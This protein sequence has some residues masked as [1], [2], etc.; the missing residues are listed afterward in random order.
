MGS[1]QLHSEL[2]AGQCMKIEG[3]SVYA[4]GSGVAPPM[5][6]GSKCE[7]EV[8]SKGEQVSAEGM[9]L[10][11]GDMCAN[12]EMPTS[13]CLVEVSSYNFTVKR[14]TITATRVVFPAV[15]PPF[16]A[17]ENQ[18]GA[19]DETAHAPQVIPFCHRWNLQLKV[20]R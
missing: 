16:V 19:I 3:R 4:G 17:A 7:P 18:P 12:H 5:L 11:N 6:G 14:R 15:L 8:L 13:Q 20:F 2:K 10:A 9:L 1:S